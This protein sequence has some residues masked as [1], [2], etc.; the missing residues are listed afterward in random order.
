M[1]E[2]DLKKSVYDLT[3]QYPE[4]TGVL[5]EL[6][7]VGLANPVLR[8]TL[9]RVTTLPQGAEKQGKDL[10]EVIR[11]LEGKGFTVKNV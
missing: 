2:L 9:G 11:I 4:L 3:E 8:N 5:K 6:G 7:F 1:K 10:E